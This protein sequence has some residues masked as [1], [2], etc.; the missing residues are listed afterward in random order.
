MGNKQPFYNEVTLLFT[1][2]RAP[3]QAE[4]DECAV[5]FQQALRNRAPLV[6]KVE[7]ES[8]ESEPGDPADLM[9]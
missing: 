2:T 3:Y 9:E 8:F 4:I 5:A 1:T 6:G 7:V